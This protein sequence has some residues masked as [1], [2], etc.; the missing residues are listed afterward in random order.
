MRKII[1]AIHLTA[2]GFCDHDV[3]I[4]GE[5]IHQHYTELLQQAGVI[6][7]GRK[8]FRLMEYWKQFVKNPLGVKDMDEFAAAM[9]AVPK[10]VFSRTMKETGWH[11]AELAGSAS[12]GG[13]QKAIL[14]TNG[15]P[16]ILSDGQA[17]CVA[18]R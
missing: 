12:S 13:S 8:T 15:L 16:A 1:A 3:I 9:D 18:V 4:P 7:Y 6:L 14:W 17:F 2:N 10:V 11:R 5:E